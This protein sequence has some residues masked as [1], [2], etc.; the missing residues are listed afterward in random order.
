MNFSPKTVKHEDSIIF[1]LTNVNPAKAT[2]FCIW[3]AIPDV[4]VHTKRLLPVVV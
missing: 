1:I 3:Y 2:S 4:K